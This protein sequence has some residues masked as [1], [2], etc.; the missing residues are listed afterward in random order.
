MSV[1]NLHKTIRNFDSIRRGIWRYMAA[2]ST[3]LHIHDSLLI[4]NKKPRISGVLAVVEGNLSRSAYFPICIATY[5]YKSHKHV[6]SY[7]VLHTFYPFLKITK[8]VVCA[9]ILLSPLFTHFSAQEIGN[10]SYFSMLD[11]V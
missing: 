6:T 2:F 8:K 3:F 1:L 4:Y 10:F 5:V 11:V 9:V 7:F